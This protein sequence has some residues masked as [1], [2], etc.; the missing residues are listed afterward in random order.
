MASSKTLKQAKIK[1]SNLKDKYDDGNDWI[2]YC[3]D[4][5]HWVTDNNGVPMEV[6]M[7][8]PPGEPGLPGEPG[9]D[10]I[11]KCDT[12]FTCDFGNLDKI[13]PYPEDRIK[14]TA[15]MLRH[16][17]WAITQMSE[18][19][20][21][22]IASD[23]YPL[24]IKPNDS[25]I[26]AVSATSGNI[27]SYNNASG[28]WTSGSYSSSTVE[29]GIINCNHTMENTITGEIIE[30]RVVQ[31][32]MRGS[33]EQINKYKGELGQFVMN[34]DTFKI[35]VMD[36]IRPGGYVISGGV[37]LDYGLFYTKTEMDDMINNINDTL[38]EVGKLI[39]RINGEVI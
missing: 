1:R 27:T 6:G 29:I 14:P 33:T 11:V 3:D 35:H 26:P 9:K 20:M 31:Q 39:D 28:E 21:R 30:P 32:Q 15:T 18:T 23:S 17:Y 7:Q 10:F 38:G 5:T 24:I 12:V 34:T 8:G 37:D 19:A 4:G 22:F 13:I 16:K 36:G 2:L 25:G